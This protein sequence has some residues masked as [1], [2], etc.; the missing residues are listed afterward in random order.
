MASW[1]F[2]FNIYLNCQMFYNNW[3]DF[4]PNIKLFT[5]YN[6]FTEIDG[7]FQ[8]IVMW[9]IFQFLNLSNFSIKAIKEVDFDDL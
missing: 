8:N 7:Q 3:H 9:N 5:K 4:E 2:E 6:E 1:M